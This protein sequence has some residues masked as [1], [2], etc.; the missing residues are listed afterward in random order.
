MNYKNLVTLIVLTFAS[1]HS[2]SYAQ[3]ERA[4]YLIAAGLF[5]GAATYSPL[6]MAHSW[7]EREQKNLE[8][9][10]GICLFSAW[11][12]LNAGAVAIFQASLGQSG[13][14]EFGYYC[15]F[16]YLFGVTVGLL[17][18]Y[19]MKDYSHSDA[20]AQPKNT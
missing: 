4:T 16:A 14:A 6:A 5:G 19:Q 2:S 1:F 12:L 18:I 13:I 11:V 15:A 3:G 9:R 20:K 7:Q 8:A 10:Q 17:P